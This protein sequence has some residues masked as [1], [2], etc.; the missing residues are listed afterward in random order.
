MPSV[1]SPSPHN[2][3][4]CS[5]TLD[6]TQIII[7]AAFHLFRMLSTPSFIIS[8]LAASASATGL[9]HPAHL[10]NKREVQ[11]RETGSMSTSAGA[12]ATA[13]LAPLLAAYSSL[14]TPCPAIVSYEQSHPVTDACSYSIPDSLSSDFSVY[15][16]E[17]KAWYR[18]HAADISSALSMCP[19]FSSLAASDAPVCATKLDLPGGNAPAAATTTMMNST[20]TPAAGDVGAMPGMNMSG[21]G[22]TPTAAG[23]GATAKAA[24]ARETGYAGAV[25]AVAAVLAAAV[26]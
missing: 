14:P 20:S 8:A 13:C 11:A 12:D 21:A 24:G 3:L 5:L 15:E 19:Q 2:R 23:T 1:F 9:L 16:T 6:T 17:V 18:T 25:L 26:L 7:S 22:M 4:R 10:A